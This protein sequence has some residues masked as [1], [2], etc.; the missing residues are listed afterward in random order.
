MSIWRKGF[1]LKPKLDGVERFS[2]KEHPRKTV[3]EFMDDDTE[4][5]YGDENEEILE[6]GIES[7][8]KLSAAPAEDIG[9]DQQANNWQSEQQTLYIGFIHRNGQVS[10]CG[11]V[12]GI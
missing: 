11:C 4:E 5:E 8:P 9:Q 3:D 12:H 7:Q 10:L 1:Y 2:A 6:Q